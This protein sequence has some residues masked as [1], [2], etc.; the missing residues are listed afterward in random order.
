MKK[1]IYI[2][3]LICAS[4]AFW[5]DLYAQLNLPIGSNPDAIDYSYFPNRT[6]ALV[7]R[8]WDLVS[9]ERIAAA[10]DCTPKQVNEIAASMGLKKSINI[11]PDFKRRMYITVVRR[12]WHLLPYE[13]LLTLL[14]MT[15]QE[16]DIAL[17]DDDFLY[18]KLGNLKPKVEKIVYANP[19]TQDLVRAK[20]IRDLVARQ[21]KK[22]P[23]KPE[24]R[25]QFLREF[26]APVTKSRALSVTEHDDGLRYIYSYFGVFGDP[27]VDTT[28]DPYPDGLLAQLAAKGING[29]WMHVVLNHMAPGGPKF[30]EFGEDHEKRIANLRRIVERAGKFGIKV[31]LYMNEPRAMPISF[32][33]NRPEMAGVREG[34]LAAMCTS[35]LDV[36]E[37][38]SNS[39]TYVF[40]EVPKLGGVFTIT[41][42]ENLTSCASHGQQ[43]NCPRCSKRSFADLIAGVNKTI[44]D[45]VHRG[46]PEAKVIAWDWGWNH[47]APEIIAKLPKS[48]WFMSVS[49]W[50]TPYERGG[51]KAHVGEYSM[52]VV[53][54]GE[55]AKRNWKAA[56]EAGIKTVA[57][58]QFNNTW[59]FSAIPW[60]PVPDLVARH[61]SQLAKEKVDGLMLSWSL[62]GYPSPNLEIAEAYSKNPGADVEAVLDGLAEKHYGNAAAAEVRKAWTIFSRAFQ[63]IPFSANVIYK[64]P[65]QTGP[66]N[67]VYV[68]PTGFAATMVGIPYDDLNG[69][70]APF[71][72]A[73]FTSQFEKLAAEWNRGLEHFAKAIKLSGNREKANVTRDYNLAQAAYIHFAS[74]ANQASF[75]KCRDSLL[76][77]NISALDTQRIKQKI[78]TL[79]TSEIELATRLYEITSLDSRVGFE[80][81][82]QYFYVPQ[83][84]KEKVINCEFVMKEL[85]I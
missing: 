46:N 59:E 12:N 24:M 23:G 66:S 50:N 84:L 4:P 41:G 35:N 67:L 6:F 76:D 32:F 52:S 19:S 5:S 79:L 49:E 18:V 61:A 29:V 16:L 82:N 81:S 38:I 74:V 73:V 72:Q 80:A 62:G 13:Q 57:K 10:I 15:A 77:K 26:T 65:L 53:G 8:N 7:W 33:A 58:V 39:L 51:V 63:E 70:T 31:Y 34:D 85:D 44:A 3:L 37:W 22:F 60:L 78:K 45:G 27:L 2:L 14:D 64:A 20:E 11:P 25:F 55:M 54:P 21:F 40:K 75:I 68:K 28:I 9:P 47:V 83:D 30:P 17:K 36:N 69:W 48:V 56:R 71:P 43:H 42:S 1:R